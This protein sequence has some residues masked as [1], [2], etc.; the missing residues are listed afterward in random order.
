MNNQSKANYLF[1]FFLACLAGLEISQAQ[2]VS[3]PVV[4]F[5]STTIKGTGSSGSSQFFSLVPLQLSKPISFSG[6]ATAVGTTVTVT[7]G[8]LASG[9]YN[10]G[11]SYPT[12]YLR[13]ESGTGAGKISDIVSNTTGNITTSDDLSAFLGSTTQISV[14]PHTKLTDVLGVSGSQLIAGGT[15]ASGSDNVY[16]VGPD[17]SFKVYYYK[18]GVGAGLK[19]QSNADAT[20]LVVYPG[21]AI[22]VGRRQTSNTA[23]VVITGQL[24]NT[25]SIVPVTQGYNAT[26]GGLPVSF[27]LSNLTSLVQGGTASGSADNVF[28]IDPVD[29][30]MKLYYYK[31]G[32]G[33]GW[34]NSANATVSATTDISSGF[35]INRRPAN[36]FDIVQTPTW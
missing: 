11:A 15:S 12:H 22:L 32:V 31:T 29:G 27:T 28:L 8:S 7:P 4:G 20:A 13:I 10:S 23:S 1:S 17:G 18:T 24:A 19:T 9:A 25:S 34:K 2:T 5:T 35:V 16:L 26:A 3:T 14:I 6:P 36:S 30:Q 33:A 21:E